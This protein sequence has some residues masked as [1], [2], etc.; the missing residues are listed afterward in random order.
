M[1]LWITRI[2]GA[3][4]KGVCIDGAG[5]GELVRADVSVSREIFDDNGS[6]FVAVVSTAAWEHPTNHRVQIPNNLIT[7]FNMIYLW[8]LESWR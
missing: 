1:P 6:G 4:G 5:S 8:K 7:V 2:F 3:I